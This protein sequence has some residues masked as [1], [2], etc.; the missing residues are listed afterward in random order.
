MDRGICK[1]LVF[2]LFLFLSKGYCQD[3]PKVFKQVAA[4]HSNIHFEN[5]VEETTTFNYYTFMHMYMGA[6][7][8][9]GDFNK[10][11]LPDIYFTA[12]KGDNT[13]YLNKGNLQFLDIA[14]SAG[15]QGNG[16]FYTGVTTVDINNDGWLD[17]YICRSGPETDALQRNLLYINNGDLT[18]TE[19]SSSYGLSEFMSHSIQSSFFDYDNDGDLDV[20]IVNTPVD[21]KMANEVFDLNKI[22]NDPS[23]KTYGGADKLYRNNGDLTFTDVSNEAGILPDIFFGLTVSIADLNEDGW[24]DIYVSNDFSGP[25]L[26]YINNQNGT[27]TERAKQMFSHISN[28]SMGADIGDVNNDG[29]QDIF[30]LDMLPED[31]KRSKTSMSMMPRDVMY[32]MVQSGYHWQYMH[33]VLQVNNGVFNENAPSFQELGYFAGIENTDWSWSCL[34]ADFD[35]DGHNDI[36]VTNG[37]LRDV[38]N[39][40]ARIKQKEYTQELKASNPNNVGVEELKK[41][42]AFFPSVKLSNYL[43][44]NNGDLTFTDISSSENVGKPSFSNGSAYADF[45]NDGDLDL[46]CNN[47]ND[48]AFLFENRASELGNHY[49]KVIVKGAPN[50]HFGYGSKVKLTIGNTLQVK[51]LLSTRGYFSASEPILHFGLGKVGKIDKVEITWPDGKQQILQKVRADQELV[52]EYK[53]AKASVTKKVEKSTL[54]REVP[55]LLEPDF[56]H[57]DISNDDF[58][59]Q[60]LLPHKLSSTGPC[61]AVGDVNNDGLEDFFVG[62]ATWFSG[63][64]YV[65]KPSGKFE[66]TAQPDLEVDKKSEDTAAHFFD[67]NNDGY[68]DL[69]VASGSYEAE[70]DSSV[71]H[72]RLYINNGTGQF[73]KDEDAL[74]PSKNYGSCIASLDFDQDGDQDLF[75]GGRT[76]KGKYP[77]AA[78]SYILQNENGSF[79]DVTPTRGKD[80]QQLGMVTD[81]IS[82]DFDQDG[83]DDLILVGEWM[84]ITFLKNE[85]GYLKNVT[86]SMG[87]SHTAGWWNTIEAHDLDNDG[88]TDYVLGNL[89]LNYKFHAS[90]E[91]PFH[92]YAHDFDNTG[93]VDIV[94]AKDMDNELFPVRGKMCSTE[95]M[96]FIKE[97]FPT[98]TGFAEANLTDILGQSIQQALHLEVQE[99]QSIIIWN[100]GKGKFSIQPLPNEAQYSV[101]NGIVCG[102]FDQDGKED[103]LLAGNRFETEVETSRS[104]AGN[105]LLLKGNGKRNFVPVP[106]RISGFFAPENVKSLIRIKKSKQKSFVLVGANNERIKTF[107]N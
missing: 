26:L 38:T 12:N 70:P 15:V 101:V 55:R 25:D 37:I 75:V 8:A 85:N 29:L 11:K 69:Y 84:P 56:V 19:S 98:F 59:D 73:V 63:A 22:Y 28:Y 89:G 21:F 67:A 20:Y 34:I 57:T 32:N 76:E 23:F 43:F 90:K 66:R 1:I 47:V 58:N 60:V 2:G 87:F 91:K 45:D 42:R 14:K 79:K 24:K 106:S 49:L 50:N 52:F 3:I 71:L 83:D 18:F 41:A 86:G 92:I 100:N 93:T 13:L 7:V 74:P 64:I 103:I 72:D 97:K 33:N 53:D 4:Q 61:M 88:S 44:K 80:V 77:Y 95:Q 68:L 16:G 17:I 78:P 107:F 62:G 36:H 30:V 35:L 54:L 9:V 81:A 6:G 96:P 5:V 31:Y 102:D 99:F 39:M 104:D 105:G 82:T 40:D 46:V 65:Q 51:E 94:L 27:F 10:D 48:K